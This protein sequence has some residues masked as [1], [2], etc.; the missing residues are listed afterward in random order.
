MAQMFIGRPFRI[1]NLAHQLGLYPGDLISPA[2]LFVKR[3][4]IRFKRVHFSVKLL[5]S[6]IIKTRAAIADVLYLFTRF[7]AKDERSKIFP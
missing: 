6:L 3:F 1:P 5:Y 7:N 4:F 2:Y